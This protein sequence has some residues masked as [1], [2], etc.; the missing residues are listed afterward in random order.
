MVDSKDSTLPI[1]LFNLNNVKSTKK[2]VLINLKN[3]V[4]VVAKKG[5][6]LRYLYPE[7]SFAYR[8]SFEYKPKAHAPVFQEYLNKLIPDRSQQQILAEF[9][10]Y[11]FFIEHYFRPC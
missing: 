5:R 9:I 2:Q 1:S 3:G 4:L 10:A 11:L 8:V 7:D 6:I